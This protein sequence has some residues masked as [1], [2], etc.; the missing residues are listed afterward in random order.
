MGKNGLNRVAM[1]EKGIFIARF[2]S[3]EECEKIIQG[4]PVFFDYKPLITKNGIRKWKFAKNPSNTCH[5]GC[6]SLT[7]TLNIGDKNAYTN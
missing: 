5:F 7:C 2:N 1:L 6:G 4:E 3:E